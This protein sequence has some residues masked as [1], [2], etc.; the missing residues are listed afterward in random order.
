MTAVIT[1]RSSVPDV[2][3]WRLE[4]DKPLYEIID[5]LRVEKTPMSILASRV[6][7]NLFGEL[8][9]FLHDN[10]VGEALTETLFRLPLPV[11]RKRRP[12]IAFVLALTIAQ[13]L[14][15]DGSENAW[16]VLPELM[17]E[18]ASPHDL[19]DD[20]LERINEYFAAGV[21]LMWVVYPKWRLIYVYE[22]PARVRILKETDDLDGGGV[23]PGFRIAIASLFP[24]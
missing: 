3:P 15:Q 5:G 10:P 20:I 21:K 24:R 18:V 23:L 8:R 7:S 11:D 2:Q 16:A 12:D 4:N 1:P 6:A 17:V 9:H 22:G 19:A 14:P 13:A